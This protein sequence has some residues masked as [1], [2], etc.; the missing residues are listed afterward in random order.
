MTKAAY[1]DALDALRGPFGHEDFRPGQEE[2]VRAVMGGRDV[3]AIMPTGGGKSVVYQVP[4]IA[5][6]GMSICVSPLISLMK[7]Q[8]DQLKALGLRPAYLN[9]SLSPMQQ[10]VVMRRAAAGAY[11]I[12]YVAPERLENPEFLEMLESVE[13]PLVAVDEAHCISSWGHD[14]RPDYKKIG[15]F[16]DR[17]GRR[18]VVVALTATA[19]EKVQRDIVRM[20]GLRDPA[21]VVSGFDRPNIM[22]SAI[23]MRRSEKPCWSIS[24][25][26]SRRDDCGIFYC[27][28]RKGV[29]ELC[30]ELRHAGIAATRYHAGLAEGERARNQEAFA[31]GEA[32][33]MVATTAFGMGVNKRDIRY[34]VNY[35][36]PMSVEDYYQ[37]A[38]RAG[39]D[40]LP[41][42]SVLL[43][44]DGDVNTALFLAERTAVPA[45]TPPEEAKRAEENRKRLVWRMRDYCQCVGCRRDF[46]LRYF[47]ERARAEGSCGHCDSCAPAKAAGAA[48]RPLGRP[49]QAAKAVPAGIDPVLLDDLKRLRKGLAGDNAAFTVFSNAVM[50]RICEAR[51]T[52]VGEF[53]E[54]R[55]IGPAKAEAYGDAVVALMRSHARR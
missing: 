17:F 18:P 13:V 8:V 52:T 9:S 51:P 53:L 26:L 27:T 34:V 2:A 29:E 49:R 7:D 46:I 45:D 5:M 20:L 30:L 48:F 47:G 55:G 21:K 24:Y 4:A 39:R 40:G 42:D 3:L 16:L 28:S 33:V 22:L 6:G 31:R 36:M 41:S 10:Q 11:Q 38:G 1:E 37:Q 43:W 25:A 19:T 12:M 44:N 23:K 15:A 54:I 32:K 14:F 35:N 50:L